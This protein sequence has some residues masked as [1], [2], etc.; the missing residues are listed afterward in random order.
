MAALML[1]EMNENE[2][3]EFCAQV[4]KRLG[5]REVEVVSG[6]QDFWGDIKMVSPEKEKAIVL[7]IH[8]L[9]REVG[10]DEIYCFCEALNKSEYDKGIIICTGRVSKDVLQ[11]I[12]S[13]DGRVELWDLARFMKMVNEVG[14]KLGEMTYD[15]E[16]VALPAMTKDKII[17]YVVSEL[18]N[19][20]GF[21]SMGDAGFDVEIDIEYMPV[22]R[23][24][25][26]LMRSS[27]GERVVVKKWEGFQIV[28]ID[29]RDGD[30]LPHLNIFDD[31]PFEP[32]RRA[33]SHKIHDFTLTAEQAV[34]RVYGIFGG[35][36]AG[37][38]SREVQGPEG[39]NVTKVSTYRPG[40]EITSVTK[41]FLSI[42]KINVRILDKAYFITCYTK[43]PN[44][45]YM[46]LNNLTHCKKCH[47]DLPSKELAVCNK[48]GEV[49]HYRIIERFKH[50]CWKC[51]K[52]VC[53]ECATTRR[54]WVMIPVRY[55]R[56]CSQEEGKNEGKRKQHQMYEETPMALSKPTPSNN[57]PS[58][59]DNMKK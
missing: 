27:L 28:Y 4:L 38:G 15:T 13:L 55:C 12:D 19:I 59:N 50:T 30:H 49:L 6:R 44:H 16:D 51:L 32:L 36:Y 14:V 26:R 17:E 47:K 11:F 2:F 5:Y 48:C 20:R 1:G 53:E 35:R 43:P 37:T 21:T 42:F 58:I 22:Y 29:G 56:T 40:I 54:K 7:C 52:I 33:E 45:V 34:E 9:G 8:R 57:A 18:L 31:M 10:K 3:K 24:E 25:Y 46:I 41:V 23:I 39:F